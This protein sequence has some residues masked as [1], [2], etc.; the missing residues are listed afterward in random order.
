MLVNHLQHRD[1]QMKKSPSKIVGSPT[2][3]STLDFTPT[4]VNLV[5]ENVKVTY[6][7][8]FKYLF[9]TKEHEAL[10]ID[11]LNAFLFEELGHKIYSLTFIDKEPVSSHYN[12]KDVRYDICCR[13]DRGEKINIE[14]QLANHKDMNKRAVSFW[15]RLHNSN[16]AKG[17]KFSETT[18]S[19]TFNILNFTLFH[20]HKRPFSRWGII[21]LE[22]L[23]YKDCLPTIRL[24]KDL[25][26]CF[27]EL[28]KFKFSEHKKLSR[29]EKWLAFL[30]DDL[31]FSQK[32]ALAMDDSTLKQACEGVE[33]FFLSEGRYLAYI[34]E[35]M[36][37]QDRENQ[38]TSAFEDGKEEGIK[39]G[40][41]QGIDQNRQQ[42][43]LNLIN[44]GL[45][46]ELIKKTTGSTD[47]EI[48]ALTTKHHFKI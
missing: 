48:R 23:R 6:D 3:A 28:P 29:R 17:Q 41:Q 37:R 26:I 30:S 15:S 1:K 24:S 44:S 27:L 5:R 46:I 31:T 11:L 4:N 7:C 34:D 39:L 21:D 38:I 10:L 16:L 32:E 12:E 25:C 42:I 40:I 36:C 2:S 22:S 8:I 19:I 43:V 14:V 20:H 45:D 18:P 9:G 47:D 33:N 13:L 35:E